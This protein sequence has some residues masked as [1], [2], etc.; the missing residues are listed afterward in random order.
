MHFSSSFSIASR[1]NA[2]NILYIEFGYNPLDYHSLLTE[3]RFTCL[4]TAESSQT[5]K[6]QSYTRQICGVCKYLLNA[7]NITRTHTHAPW[8]HMIYHTYQTQ[9]N[10][11]SFGQRK[12]LSFLIKWQVYHWPLFMLYGHFYSSPLTTALGMC[13]IVF[14]GVILPYLWCLKA[15][16]IKLTEFA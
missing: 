12:L 10:R 5:N 15:L 16:N 6:A 7:V 9:N 13:A 4:S 1:V 14:Y 2:H 3:I 11:M 8:S